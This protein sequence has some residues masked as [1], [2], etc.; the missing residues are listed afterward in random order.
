MDIKSVTI[1]K[2]MQSIKGWGLHAQNKLILEL[3]SLLKI[4]QHF[5]NN[6]QEYS[7]PSEKEFIRKLK[8][9]ES[10]EIDEKQF[11]LY[12]QRG[13]K[14][15]TIDCKDYPPLLKSIPDAPLILYVKGIMPKIEFKNLSI[16]GTRRASEYGKNAILD[17]M[18]HLK[19]YKINIISGLAEGIDGMAHQAAMDNELPTYAVLGHGLQTIFPTHHQRLAEK[20]IEKGGALISE[21]DW[22]IYA[23]KINFPLRNRIVAGMCDLLWVVETPGKGGSMITAQLAQGYQR[24]LVTLPGSI[25]QKQFDG[26]HQLIKNNVAQLVTE[27]KDILSFLRL[28]Q[29]PQQPKYQQKEMFFNLTEEEQK[30]VNSLHHEGRMHVDDLAIA[31]SFSLTKLASILLSLEMNGLIKTVPGKMYELL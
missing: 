25:F 8:K 23:D 21:F 17:F 20:I 15:L 4:Q 26:N 18:E 16:V 19:Y 3:G 31:H 14:V 10:G 2:A 24:D 28:D 7:H 13:I 27:A 6:A 5:L 12:R 29:V 1:A 30:I 22:G 9:I 11:D